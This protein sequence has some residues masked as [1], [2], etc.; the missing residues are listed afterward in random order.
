M[1]NG[2]F[3]P[4]QRLIVPPYLRLNPLSSRDT[5][6]PVS[7]LITGYLRFHEHGKRRIFFG[8]YPQTPVLKKKGSNMDSLTIIT[9]SQFNFTIVKKVSQGNVR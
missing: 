6:L 1:G 2:G 4:P 8:E 5:G 3:A 9:F 7:L